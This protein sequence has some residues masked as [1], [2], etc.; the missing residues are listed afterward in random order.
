MKK[1]QYFLLALSIAIF[2]SCG[3]QDNNN[4]ETTAEDDYKIENM[5]ARGDG[6][7]AIIAADNNSP[8]NDLEITA[9]TLTAGEW[10]DL[11]EWDFW[12]KLMQKEMY[13][14]FQ[15]Q[16]QFYPTHRYSIKL[17]DNTQQAVNDCSVQLLDKNKKVIWEAKTN[18]TGVA[19]LWADPFVENKDIEGNSLVVKHASGEYKI[20]R[21]VTLTVGVNEFE[22]PAAAKAVD[23]RT[24]VMIVVD[25]TGSMEDE[26]AYMK[27]ELEDVA[28]RVQTEKPNM[29]F[30][31]GAVFYRDK[32]DEYIA[33]TADLTSDINQTFSFFN[34]QSADGGGDYPEAVDAALEEA[35]SKQQWSASAQSRIV[36]LMLDAPPHQDDKSL[37]KIQANIKKAAAQGIKIIPIA[38]SGIDKDTE[39]L[40]R[41]FS[42]ATNGSYVFLTDHSGVGNEHIEPT[43][44]EYRVEYLNDLLAR[45]I[46]QSSSKTS[47][48]I[49]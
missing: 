37:A 23:D 28:E 21:P 48:V 40:M 18:N 46:L 36:F 27:K 1:L 2:A 9:G 47:P 20:E 13:Y 29:T 14:N 32:G 41:F 16:W 26:I 6:G 12:Q 35:I 25:A 7:E 22:I 34:Q 24:E 5:T 33:R 38:S 15:S 10:N 43:V 8:E 44:G 39:F 42:L 4:E 3:T 30:Q 19:E 45:I 11:N 17:V 49:Q 31:L